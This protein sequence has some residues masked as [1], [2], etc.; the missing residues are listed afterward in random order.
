MEGEWVGWEGEGG[1]RGDKDLDFVS[2]GV[3]VHVI[4]MSFIK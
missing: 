4:S 3:K 1:K 2:N